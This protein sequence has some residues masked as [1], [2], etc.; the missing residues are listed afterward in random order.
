MQGQEVIAARLH[1]AQYL[2]TTLRARLKADFTWEEKRDLVEK[3]VLG[4]KVDGPGQI[5]VTYAFDGSVATRTAY[6]A[7]TAHRAWS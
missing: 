5:I 4:I 1:D 7:V 3:L 6:N 2:L